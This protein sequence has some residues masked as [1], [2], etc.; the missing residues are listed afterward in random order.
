MMKSEGFY[1][2]GLCSDGVYTQMCDSCFTS[3]KNIVLDIQSHA[4]KQKIFDL[5]KTELSARN[6]PY[7]NFC[8]ADGSGGIFCS[9]LKII[10]SDFYTEK[11]DSDVII[12]C[13]NFSGK[14]QEE[15]EKS[16]A[17]KNK[18]VLRAQRFISAC[19]SINNDVIRLTESYINRKKIYRFS[20]NLWQKISN[21]MKGH[22]GTETKR[23]VTSLTA[24]GVELNMSAFDELCRKMLVINDRSGACAKIIVDR[25]RRY[26]IGSGYDIISC[27]CTVNENLIEHLIIPELEFGV[28]TSKHYHRDDFNNARKIYAKRFLYPSVENIKVRTDFSIRTY[29][30]LMDEVF[31]SLENIKKTDR[32][33]DKLFFENTDTDKLAN[34]ITNYL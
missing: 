13:D 34:Q 24:E 1:Y 11:R 28:F 18:S 26:A 31:T 32:I 6:I 14:I 2:G 21:G 16:T 15:I 19:N 20:F 12:F 27:P 33:V 4:V 29:R 30:R 17:E 10:D 9:E 5:A 25:L 22:I 7:T 8:I 3:K 23:Y